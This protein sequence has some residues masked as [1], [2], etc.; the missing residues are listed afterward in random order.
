HLVT[1]ET[2]KEVIELCGAMLQYYRETGIYG[3]RTAPWVERIGFENVKAVLLDAEKRQTLWDS[4]NP[5]SY[6]HLTM[7]R[8]LAV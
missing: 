6:T 8:K 4:L 2:E 5:V 3:E 1:V 7:P